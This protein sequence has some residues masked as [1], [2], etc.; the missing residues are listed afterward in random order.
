MF[1]FLFYLVSWTFNG[2]VIWISS[3]TAVCL[4]LDHSCLTCNRPANAGRS[5]GCYLLTQVSNLI[6]P[7][8]HGVVVVAGGFL[9]CYLALSIRIRDVG[10]QTS[11]SA[12]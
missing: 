5:A 7:N 11:S 4:S 1:S 3:G 10:D 12:G 6:M 8:G 9:Y 2:L